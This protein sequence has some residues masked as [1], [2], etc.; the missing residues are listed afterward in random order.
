E[1]RAGEPA[2]VGVAQVARGEDE[3]GHLGRHRVGVQLGDDVEAVD[4]G[5]QDVADDEVEAVA[6]GQFEALDAGRRGG[7]VRVVP[8]ERGGDQLQRGRVVV[9]GQDGEGAR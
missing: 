4:V 3:H 7:G 5:Q 1:H 2:R 8:L 6:A 9:D